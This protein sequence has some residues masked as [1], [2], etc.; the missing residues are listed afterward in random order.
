[1]PR[2]ALRLATAA[3]ATAALSTTAL[4]GDFTTKRVEFLSGQDRIVGTLYVPAEARGPTPAV[5]VEG[6]QTNHKDMVPA[7]Y[8]AK[9][10]RAGYVALTFDH[11]T[12]GESSGVVRN[13]ENPHMKV[14]D[15]RQAL[16]FLKTRP[17][18]KAD[19]IGLIGI[20]SGG[21]Y[22]AKAAASEPDLKAVVTIAG[23][24]H[25][26][27]VFRAWLGDKYEARVELGR[28]ARLTFER[29]GEVDYMK[30][31]SRDLNE[32]LAMPGQ[33]AYDYYGTA[34][35]TG[36]R[37]ENRSATMFFE[38]FLQFNSID[39]GPE[40]RAATMVIHSDKAL[41]PEGAKRFYDSLRG[42]KKLHWMITREHISF[43]DEQPVVDEAAAQAISW[44][45]THLGTPQSRIAQ[46]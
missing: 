8:A 4:A 3:L 14:E 45:S 24:F 1:M 12:F 26:P 15:V 36:A 18:V 25:D 28:Q 29:T 38:S 30:N 44:F 33:E 23:F 19:A 46:N 6:P 11:R 17:E 41:V 27:A 39:A 40:I 10:A 32:E 22:S 34:R 13:N 16:A 7:T 5:L 9:L 43:Y 37:W 42:E 2:T 20:C 35:N 31:V 21:G